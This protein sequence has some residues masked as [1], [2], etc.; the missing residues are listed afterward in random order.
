MLKTSPTVLPNDAWI[1]VHSFIMA[2]LP[3]ILV[4]CSK[5][6]LAL[7][8]QK[9][10]KQSISFLRWCCVWWYLIKL[11]ASGYYKHTKKEK[12]KKQI[13]SHSGTSSCTSA[14]LHST[15]LNPQCQQLPSAA[16][17]TKICL[18][19]NLKPSMLRNIFVCL[20]F[21]SFFGG[22]GFGNRTALLTIYLSL[23]YVKSK[24]FQ[25]ILTNVRA[26]GMVH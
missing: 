16:I 19:N 26:E 12:K 1:S 17:I 18:S 24:Q 20:L 14:N 22:Y 23:E 15:Q 3:I 9:Q 8:Q 10:R 4:Q 7:C 25:S 5:G 6:T 2:S 11:I 13:H 21:C